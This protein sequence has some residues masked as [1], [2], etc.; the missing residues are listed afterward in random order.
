MAQE[1]PTREAPRN[2]VDFYDRYFKG[3]F[4]NRPQS[5]PDWDSLRTSSYTGNVTVRNLDTA[6]ACFYGVPVADL[7]RGVWPAGC[8]PAQCRFNESMPDDD[9]LIQGNVFIAVG[10]LAL[11]Y[12]TA[13]GIPHRKAV[14]Q[15]YMRFAQGLL[16]VSLLRSHCSPSSYDDIMDLLDLYPE[17]V[18]EFSTYQYN[19]GCLPHRNTV[20]WEVRNY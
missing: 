3:E 9:L 13:A 12:S 2:K 17:A 5:W 11:E 1:V 6:G 10:G 20:I 4:G 19:V 8:C 16:A 14:S 18:I 7:R 15:P